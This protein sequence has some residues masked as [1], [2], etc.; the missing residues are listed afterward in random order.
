M[1]YDTK[2]VHEYITIMIKSQIKRL[3]LQ[4]DTHANAKLE[5]A[6]FS[7]RSRKLRGVGQIL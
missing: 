2:T 6:G 7:S 4:N 1:Q 5:E 3:T